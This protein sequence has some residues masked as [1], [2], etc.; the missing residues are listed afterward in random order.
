MH[1][2]YTKIT[3]ESTPLFP[4]VYFVSY[5]YC[6]FIVSSVAILGYNICVVI[7]HKEISKQKLKQ[8]ASIFLHN[9]KCQTNDY[10]RNRSTTCDVG[11]DRQ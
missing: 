2:L 7:C 10:F 8:S 9:V 11:S 6:V 4:D 3:F 5:N 1:S